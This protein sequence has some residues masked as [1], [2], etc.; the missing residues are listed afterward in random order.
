MPFLHKWKARA[1]FVR[2]NL[3]LCVAMANKSNEAGRHV[4]SFRGQGSRAPGVRR[5]TA[6]GEG[7][8]S[9]GPTAAMHWFNIGE[10]PT[11]IARRRS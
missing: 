3:L 10:G 9:G 6:K 7:A 1:G 4:A 11:S 8:T 5:L 2:R